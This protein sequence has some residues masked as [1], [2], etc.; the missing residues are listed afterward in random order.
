MY[1]Y[2]NITFAD[3]AQRLQKH[4]KGYSIT[5][6]DA[7]TMITLC[8]YETLA[9]GYSAFCPLFTEEDCE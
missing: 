4:I 8:A 3:T 2:V 1:E 9:L 7:H 6:T 5:P